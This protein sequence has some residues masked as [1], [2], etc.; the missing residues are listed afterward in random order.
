LILTVILALA[1]QG[2]GQPSGQTPSAPAAKAGTRTIV[3]MTGRSV[4]IPTPENIQRVAV[5]TSPLVQLMYVVGA[6]DKLCAMTASQSRFKL[7]EKFYPRQAQ[8]P[9]PRRTAADINIE[10]LLAADPQFCIG[11]EVDMD[12]VEK[13]TNLPTVRISTT[14]APEQ[15]FEN[16]K[17]TVRLF[18]EIFGQP[19]RAENYCRFLDGMLRE[20][21]SRTAEL[22][23]EKRVKVYMGFNPDHL[24]TYGGDTYMQ[25]L[26]E[27]AGC[28]NAAQELSTLGGKEGGLAEVSLEQVLSWDPDLIVVDYGNAADLARDPTWSGLRAVKEGRVLRIPV[29]GFLWHR[30]SAESAALLPLWLAINA[31]P[32]RFAGVSIE[33]EIKRYYREIYGFALSDADVAGILHPV[34]TPAGGQSG[35]PNAG[36]GGGAAAGAGPA[37][38]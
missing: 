23:A 12:L 37:S 18:G 19:A 33:N 13:N 36:K 3:D 5:L 20:I 4:E 22:P 25:Y 1:V 16:H 21:K 7:F 27:A 11:S 30:S 24:T 31:Y 2:C 34:D 8:I 17:A 32:D 38:R 9:A 15:V 35:Q 26:I 10:A 14:N 28:R 6:Q 29:G